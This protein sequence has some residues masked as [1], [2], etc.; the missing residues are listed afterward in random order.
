[1]YYLCCFICTLCHLSCIAD[2]AIPLFP[3][4]NSS[5]ALVCES[6]YRLR[7][8]LLFALL[9]KPDK[10]SLDVE[11]ESNVAGCEGRVMREGWK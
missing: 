3:D 9:L 1:M 10:V 8:L 5:I 11:D 4:H 6:Y 2:S 7:C